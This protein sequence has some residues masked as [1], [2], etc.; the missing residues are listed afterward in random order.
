MPNSLLSPYLKWAGN[1]LFF[2]TCI[3]LLKTMCY[4]RKSENGLKKNE[5]TPFTVTFFIT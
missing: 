1:V 4:T 2:A 3:D 5:V